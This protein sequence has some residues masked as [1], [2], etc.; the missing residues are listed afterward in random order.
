MSVLLCDLAIAAMP[1][2]VFPDPVGRTIIPWRLFSIHLLRAS[3]WYGRNSTS[4][5][6]IVC[7]NFLGFNIPER[8]FRGIEYA[9]ANIINSFSL[10]GKISYLMEV[11]SFALK[12]GFRSLSLS[13][14]KRYVSQGMSST[15]FPL[16]LFHV[17]EIENLL[18]SFLMESS[19]SGDIL[20]PISSNKLTRSLNE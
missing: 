4:L 11:L 17:M 18:Y 9:P 6:L 2:R 10:Q 13:L 14:I 3:D 8:S 19:S 1:M 12:R 7:G 5:R 16:R 20:I 15:I